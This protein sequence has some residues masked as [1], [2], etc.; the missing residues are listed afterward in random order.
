MKNKDIPTIFMKK[1]TPESEEHFRKYVVRHYVIQRL[2]VEKVMRRVAEVEANDQ[3]D[4]QRRLPQNEVLSVFD[5]ESGEH[6]GWTWWAIHEGKFQHLHVTVKR[7]F[8]RQNYAWAIAK[9]ID[10]LALSWGY[11]KVWSYVIAQNRESVAAHEAYGAKATGI[12][13]VREL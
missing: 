4:F 10:K 6:V 3:Y 5:K 12:I 9:A 1:A 8:R 2:K 7:R 13:Y 11:H